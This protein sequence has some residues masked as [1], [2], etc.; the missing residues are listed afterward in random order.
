MQ[1]LLIRILARLARAILARHRPK[2]VAVAG[3]VGKTSTT[4]AVTAVLGRSFLTRGSAKNHNNEIGVPLTVIGAERTGGRS[5][6]AWAVILWKGLM[7]AYGPARPYPKVL[8]LEMATDRPGDLA[9]LTSIARPDV[10]VVT[11]VSEEHTEFLGDLDGVAREEGT[12][13]EALPAE[14]VAA[15]NGDDPRVAAMAGR[16]GARVVTYGFGEACRVRAAWRRTESALGTVFTRF[17]LAIAGREFDINLSGAVGVGNVYA[18]LAA[19]AV[20]EALGVDPDFIPYGLAGYQ[21]P[22]GRL[23]L[24]PGIKGTLL[25]DDTYNASPRAAALALETFREVV[26]G[27]PGRRIAALGDMLELGAISEPSHRELGRRAAGTGLDLLVAVGPLSKFTCE[28]AMAAGMSE[29][30][31]FHFH[32]AA[33]A[34]RFLQERLHPGDNVLIK[35]SRGMRMEKIV[36][37]L[38]AEPERAKE[39][40]VG[41]E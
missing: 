24:L 32:T 10:A 26:Q 25:L 2:V 30:D 14:G 41:Q 22:P 7:V 40:L 29:K 27:R 38:M 9:Y 13:V 1:S 15:L 35:G 36:K 19:A 20:A 28:E 23:R 18:A 37:E 6:F 39:L 21:P 12:I 3:S 34:G 17:G 31:V 33:E 8:V 16:T 4:R 5:P 11:A